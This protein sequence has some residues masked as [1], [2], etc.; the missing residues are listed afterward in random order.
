[1]KFLEVFFKRRYRLIINA[2]TTDRKHPHKT[3][4]G[5]RHLKGSNAEGFLGLKVSKFDSPDWKSWKDEAAI[6]SEAP[7]KD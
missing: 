1:M 2:D 7:S 5:Q 6:I 3:C 4:S